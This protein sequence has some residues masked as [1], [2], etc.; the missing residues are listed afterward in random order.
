MRPSTAV[1]LLLAL[2]G[3]AFAQTGPLP[4]QVGTEVVDEVVAPP[5]SRNYIALVVGLS[6]Y[7]NLPDEVELDFAR[8]DAAQVE[9]TL[10]ESAGF[11]HTFL[12]TDREA[13]RDGIRELIRNEAAQLIGPDDVFL[14]YFVGHGIGADLGLPTLLAYDSTLQNGQQD[15]LELA[16]FASEIQTWTRAGATVV[17]TDVIH[18]NQLDGVYFYGPAANQWPSVNPGTLVISASQAESPGRDGAFGP[19]FSDAMA[20]A[21][22]ANKDRLI[23]A[24]ELFAYLVS[25]VSPTGQIPVAAGDF[26]GSMVVARGV[27]PGIGANGAD[28]EPEPIYPDHEI[29]SA[30]FVFR[31]GGSPTVTCREA[32]TKVCDPSCYVRDFTAGPCDI[33]AVVDG[34]ER[35][36]RVVA[37]VPGKYECGIRSGELVCTPPRFT[38]DAPPSER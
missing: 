22:D 32:E 14:L 1:S 16:Q 13:T 9:R 31:N 8:S 18:R 29:W 4:I 37:L 7:G 5:A 30:K 21:A 33:S 28:V 12:L 2:P 15:G 36:G 25:R 11:N 38:G 19:V 6:T 24:S 27:T 26:A 3:S 35:K 20:G 17:V 10:R 23:T 34:A